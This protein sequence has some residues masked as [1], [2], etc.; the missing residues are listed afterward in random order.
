[1]EG[2]SIIRRSLII[3]TVGA[4]VAVLLGDEAQP[5]VV[6]LMEAGARKIRAAAQDVFRA[7]L[8][9]EAEEAETALELWKDLEPLMRTGTMNKAEELIRSWKS[10]TPSY[11]PLI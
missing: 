2:S 10:V 1:M 6:A 11:S 4:E 8:G 5:K 9:F 3:V 7:K